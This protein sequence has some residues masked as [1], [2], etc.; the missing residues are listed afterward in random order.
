M[1]ECKGADQGREVLLGREPSD[2]QDDRRT[3]VREPRVVG[4]LLR[5]RPESGM[6]DRIVDL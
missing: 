3:T 2:A 5:P 1:N 6:D 4:G